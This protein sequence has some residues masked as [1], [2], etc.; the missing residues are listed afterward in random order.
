MKDKTK[1]VVFRLYLEIIGFKVVVPIFVR[2]LDD[3]VG[4][5]MVLN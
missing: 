2:S 4:S 5:H 1:H 3:R